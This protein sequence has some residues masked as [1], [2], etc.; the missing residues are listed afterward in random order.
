M[1]SVKRALLGTTAAVLA[2]G[3]AQAW[4]QTPGGLEEIVVTARKAEERL[5]DIPLA[6]TAFTSEEMSRRGMTELEDVA[7]S[8]PGLVFEDFATTFSAAPVMRGLTQVNVS[9]A[10]QN[11]STFV[12]GIYIQRNYAIDIGNAD[13]QRIE[14]IKGPQSALYGQNAFAGAINYVMA[15]PGDEYE[16]L[17][18]ATLGTDGRRDYK[19]AAGGPVAGDKAGVRVGFA[20]SLYDG[21]WRNNFP[22]VTGDFAKLGGRDN[23]TFN[24]AAVIR[25][26][27]GLEIDGAYMR[28]EREEELRANY[29][30]GAADFQNRLNCGPVINA[31][32][33]N[34]TPPPLAISQPNSPRLY[35]GELPIEPSRF[36]SAR[37]TRPAGLVALPQ[38]PT[39]SDTDFYRLNISYEFNEDLAAIFQM[40]RVR[41]RS[42]EL[43]AP[44]VNA[45]DPSPNATFGGARLQSVQK[46]GGINNFQ[47]HE[48]RVE[49]TPDGPVQGRIGWYHAEV[50]DFY[51]FQLGALP[52]RVPLVNTT[53]G[54]FDF[55]GFPIPLRNSQQKDM[56]TAVFG[57]IAVSGFD[58]RAKL[59]VEARKNWEHRRFI[60]NLARFTLGQGEPGKFD[61]FTPRITAEYRIMDDSLVYASAAKGVKAGGFNGLRAGTVTLTPTEQVFDDEKNWT[62]EIGTKNTLL[63]GRW[64]LNADV[65]YVDW[66]QMQIQALP[67]NTPPAVA[68]NTPV[69]F[70]NLGNARSQG[71][72]VDTAF[73]VTEQLALN[74]GL[75]LIDPKFKSGTRSFRFAPVCDDIVCPRSTAVGGNTL[76]RTSKLQLV[77]GAAWTDTLA[78]DWEYYVRADVTH[79]SKQYVEEM[80]LAWVPKRTIVNASAGLS[81]ENWEVSV[82]AKNLFNEKYVANSFFIIQGGTYSPSLGEKF[83]AGVTATLR[84]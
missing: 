25:P 7:R 15:K 34:P 42:E 23:Q 57:Q 14:V 72:E 11:V 84:Y 68:L 49:Y 75:S 26:V 66:K 27:D 32:F 3:A 54:T 51:G 71:V 6:V 56:A 21:T 10:V 30:I 73:A 29:G 31:A 64:I 61:S 77:A 47:S 44:A 40:G 37:S 38:P 76:P 65:F 36:Q 13:L 80:N 4:A 28:V 83:T 53:T 18:S 81:Q 62:Y 78:N 82:W 24:V 52:P 9:A 2:L 46:Q 5:Q 48:L 22:G 17:A 19:F 63:D 50:K 59:T 20:K 69:I 12:D 58:N 45:A 35:C 33:P 70:L 43:S 39:T 67:S 74:A 16:A 79:Q 60:D 55:T 41:S 1:L 8:T